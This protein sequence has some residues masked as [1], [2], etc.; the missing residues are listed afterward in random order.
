MLPSQ[1]IKGIYRL[2]TVISS[3]KASSD[4]LIKDRELDKSDNKSLESMFGK[5]G[6]RDV[7]F[8]G[9]D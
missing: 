8:V 4:L 1:L 9:R 6:V 2:R 7:Q 5:L 3:E